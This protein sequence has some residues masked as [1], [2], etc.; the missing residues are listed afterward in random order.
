MKQSHTPLPWATIGKIIYGQTPED[1]QIGG[2]HSEDDAAFIT[3]AC[4]SH[5]ELLEALQVAQRAILDNARPFE[6]RDRITLGQAL[7]E[8]EYAIAKARG[9]S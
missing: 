6:S 1:G 7:S 3:K 9:E 8:I 4:N 2:C 5:Y